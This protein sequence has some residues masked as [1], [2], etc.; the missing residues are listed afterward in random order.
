MLL[1]IDIV[2]T[3]SQILCTRTRIDTCLAFSVGLS[4]FRGLPQ[5]MV[6]SSRCLRRDFPK[7]VKSIF[8][9]GIARKLENPFWIYFDTVRVPYRSEY[10]TYL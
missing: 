3:M 7:K 6:V 5:D 2:P 4:R 1:H 10:S 8:S 9:Y